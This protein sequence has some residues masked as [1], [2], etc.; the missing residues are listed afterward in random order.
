MD[1]LLVFALHLGWLFSYHLHRLFSLNSI[2]PLLKC[3]RRNWKM[4]PICRRI[5]VNT[6]I[7]G[8][9]IYIRIKD[10]NK[11]SRIVAFSMVVTK[12]V[13]GKKSNPWIPPVTR[14]KV[15]HLYKNINYLVQSIRPALIVVL[16][17]VVVVVRLLSRQTVLFSYYNI[18]LFLCVWFNF[19]NCCCN[20]FMSKW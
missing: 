8:W 6:W 7:V 11:S 18:L 20:W 12:I 2:N 16:N 5:L 15:I 17:F 1:R 14:C 3:K 13:N 9:E 19:N 4:I 10:R